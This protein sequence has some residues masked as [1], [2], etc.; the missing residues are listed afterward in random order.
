[1]KIIR[2]SGKNLASLREE[3]TVDF[4]DTVTASLFA[5]VGDTGAGKSTILDSL[6]QN[7]PT[8]KVEQVLLFECKLQ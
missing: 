8:L 2:V 4:Q 5:L 6:N 7:L 1:M 3:F